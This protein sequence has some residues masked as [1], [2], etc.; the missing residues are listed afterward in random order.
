MA[1]THAV[2]SALTAHKRALWLTPL[3]LLLALSSSQYLQIRGYKAEQSSKVSLDLR[4]P[5]SYVPRPEQ[6]CAQGGL[7]GSLSSQ[8][9]LQLRQPAVELA[10]DAALAAFAGVS[11]APAFVL[12]KGSAP[13]SNE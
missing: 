9:F 1:W 3:L 10:P 7:L 12:C 2:F 11:P 13:A 4:D 6:R 5:C 8:T